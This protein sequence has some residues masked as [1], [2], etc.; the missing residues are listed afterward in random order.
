MKLFITKPLALPQISR[1]SG[2]L[3]KEP[4]KVY[5]VAGGLHRAYYSCLTED[6]AQ[7]HLDSMQRGFGMYSDWAKI[8]TLP[9]VGM[10]CSTGYGSDSYAYFV[11]AVAKHGMSATIRR[12]KCIPTNKHEG[13]F[14]VQD[15]TYELDPVGSKREV[16][17]SRKHHC[18]DNC[19][20]GEAREYA[21]PSF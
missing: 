1:A 18:F 3:R 9:E 8:V 10:G 15:Y 7:S 5:K 13:R 2:I 16:K 20:F 4:A 6:E 11:I 19:Y 17:W 21:D 14:G 12:A